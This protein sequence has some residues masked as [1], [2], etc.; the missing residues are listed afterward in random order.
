LHG[1][2]PDATALQAPALSG[3]APK[4]RF[5]R[6]QVQGRKKDLARA[7]VGS[8]RAV[9]VQDPS[10]IR[11]RIDEFAAYLG[12][13][14]PIRAPRPSESQEDFQPHKGKPS[15]AIDR[16]QPRPNPFLT[17][18]GPDPTAPAAQLST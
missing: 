3:V 10:I 6:A 4:A 11:S 7:Q 16:S 8:S 2:G 12:C 9:R 5:A 1:S 15:G 13:L 17:R 18:R 14:S